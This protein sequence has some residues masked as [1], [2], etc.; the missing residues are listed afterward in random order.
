MPDSHWW[1][2]DL[3]ANASLVQQENFGI[4]SGRIWSDAERFAVVGEAGLTPKDLGVALP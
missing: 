2:T 1:A 4:N 3:P